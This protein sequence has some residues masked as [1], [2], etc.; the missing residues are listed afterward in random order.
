MKKSN[1]WI[2]IALL[3]FTPCLG[4]T[5]TDSNKGKV[6]RPKLIIHPAEQTPPEPTSELF[7]YPGVVIAKGGSWQG[8]DHL[9]NLSK[10]IAIQVNIVKPE[11]SALLLE[12]TGLEKIVMESFSGVG[13]S[14]LTQ[15][16]EGKPP[17]PFFSL[18]ILAYPTPG[19]YAAVCM[20]R[21]FEEI[22]LKRISLDR[23]STFQAVTWEQ[24][25]LIVGPKEGF[26]KQVEATI[27][28]IA[29]NFTSRFSASLEAPTGVKKDRPSEPLSIR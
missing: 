12:K 11:E 1:G 15:G 23:G 9:I 14:R 4:E 19:G 28:A 29:T 21:L 26:E 13:I 10:E 24:V 20:G 3:F 5:K 25:N 17:L 27:N 6:S 18:F 22:T 2:W 16:E 7:P 8:G